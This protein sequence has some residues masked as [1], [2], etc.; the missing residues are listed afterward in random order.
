M[1]FEVDNAWNYN[2]EHLNLCPVCG[3]EIVEKE[4][5]KLLR[6]GGNRGGSVEKS[7]NLVT[8]SSISSFGTS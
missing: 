7:I 6:D 3:G 4:V 8:N 1:G 2:M 5:T